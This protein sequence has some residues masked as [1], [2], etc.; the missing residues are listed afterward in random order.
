MQVIPNILTLGRAIR[1]WSYI[2][3]IWFFWCNSIGCWC[4]RVSLSPRAARLCLRTTW[5]KKLNYFA[6]TATTRSS[7]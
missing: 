3:A 7:N 5:V 6:H 4:D 1:L 2:F